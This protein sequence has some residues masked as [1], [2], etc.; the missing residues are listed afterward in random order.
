MT[1]RVQDPEKSAIW[2]ELQS[3]L[4]KWKVSSLKTPAEYDRALQNLDFLVSYHSQG[5]RSLSAHFLFTETPTSPLT[6]SNTNSDDSNLSVI[7][8]NPTAET[9]PE[10]DPGNEPIANT[11]AVT[12]CVQYRYISEF[13]VVVIG[14]STKSFADARQDFVYQIDK[15]VVEAIGSIQHDQMFGLPSRRYASSSPGSS[16]MSNSSR[17]S[18]FH[19]DIPSRT[20]TPYSDV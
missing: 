8:T 13:K 17:G 1:P 12:L 15:K 7:D 18:A 6:N 10:K 4:V 2:R 5:D 11:F 19:T 20:S 14:T 16:S 9:S 3:T